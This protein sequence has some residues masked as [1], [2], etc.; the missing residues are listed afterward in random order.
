MHGSVPAVLI[1]VECLQEVME[2]KKQAFDAKF[3]AL[4][5][6][7]GLGTKILQRYQNRAC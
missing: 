5:A 4:D 3:M 7:K 2:E 6:A 1:G